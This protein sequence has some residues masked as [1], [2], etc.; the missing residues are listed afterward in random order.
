LK[1]L[2]HVETEGTLPNSFYDATVK[3]IPK[4][5]KNPKKK[6]IFR[7]ISLK[8]TNAKI[9]KFSQTESKNTSK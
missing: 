4:P 3:L 7:P 2:H 8:N 9:K 6:E 5:C 1:L